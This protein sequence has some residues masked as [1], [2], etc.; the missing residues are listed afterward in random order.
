MIKLNV[1][2]EF[3]EV[4]ERHPNGRE[5]R[6]L[7]SFKKKRMYIGAIKRVSWGGGLCYQGRDIKGNWHNLYKNQNKGVDLPVL[8]KGQTCDL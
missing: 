5:K 2:E 8:T 7:Y 3:A 6:V 4:L 1:Q